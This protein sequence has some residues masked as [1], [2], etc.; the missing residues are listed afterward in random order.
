MIIH[1]ALIKNIYQ[2]GGINHTFVSIST[3]KFWLLERD[4]LVIGGCDFVVPT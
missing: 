4:A 3:E 1:K 2:A